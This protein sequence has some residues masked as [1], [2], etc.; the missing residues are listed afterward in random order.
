MRN[1]PTPFARAAWS[2]G[3]MLICVCVALAGCSGKN[4]RADSD[5]VSDKDPVRGFLATIPADTPYAYVAVEPMPIGPMLAWIQGWAS[6]IE[7]MLPNIDDMLADEY[8]D[9]R[10][11]LVYAV[12][13]EMSGNYSVEG[14]KKLGLSTSPRFAVHGIGFLPAFRM[15]LDDPDAFRALVQRVE[16][17]SGFASQREVLGTTD[18]WTYKFDGG[19]LIVMSIINR[20]LVWGVTPQV[21]AELYTT[22]LLGAKLPEKSMANDNRISP[23]AEK[24]GFKK[25]GA[26]FI[27]FA[28]V[29]QIV[30]EP[31]TGL[32]DQ[33]QLLIGDMRDPTPPECLAETKRLV[34]QVPR[35]VFGYEEWT[36]T[37]ARIGVGIELTTGIAGRLAETTT[38]APLVNSELA[39]QAPFVAA[40]GFDVSKL[41][42]VVNAELFAVQQ[43]P[44]ECAWYRDINGFAN[45]FT[46]KSAFVPAMITNLRG[47]ALVVQNVRTAPTPPP[48]MNPQGPPNGGLGMGP[49]LKIEGIAL[50]NSTAPAALL[51]WLRTL[52]PE[53]QNVT[54]DPGGIPLA[55]PPS[56]MLAILDDPHIVLTSSALA[57]TSGLGIADEAARIVSAVP[58]Q[59]SFLTVA[60]DLKKAWGMFA[61]A[62]MPA[63]P[64][65]EA[66]AL[67][68][69]EL[70]VE[71][72]ETAIFMHVDMAMPAPKPKP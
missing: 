51:A 16:K 11:K 46:A 41:L 2:A 21:S 62:G 34:E 7:A 12:V 45:E 28:R 69:T 58:T 53:F 15:D 70:I 1:L 32:N 49:S 40:F 36:G 18:F 3:A 13:S 26:G 23:V 72:R 39:G 47:G 5:L 24:H 4:K 35:M 67:G 63:S 19:D 10:T 59:P 44:Y 50:V 27:D 54:P 38:H 55:L 30:L 61:E 9:P 37:R 66:F 52:A 68:R 14:F 20:Q 17:R 65:I 6:S 48:S 56:E 25:F 64:V 22:Y 71:P 29:A 43:R 8:I 57:V 31:G 42:D 60:Y 33:I